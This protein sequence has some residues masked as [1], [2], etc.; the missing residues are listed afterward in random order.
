I[1]GESFESVI[2]AGGVLDP[3]IT[4]ALYTDFI[5]INDKAQLARFGL[6]TG[7]HATLANL[8]EKWEV[9]ALLPALYP[10]HPNDYFLFIANDN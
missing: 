6:T 1:L 3:A 8:S 7:V 5:D 4:P 9:L 10:E 2:A